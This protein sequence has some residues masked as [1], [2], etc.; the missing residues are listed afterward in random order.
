MDNKE[1]YLDII[2]REKDYKEIRS[3]TFRTEIGIRAIGQ[4]YHDHSS[5][6]NSQ[7]NVLR[8]KKNIEYRLFSASHQYLLLLR[9]LGS[10]ENHLKNLF[11][12]NPQ[13]M[14]WR[15]AEMTNPYFD[16]VETQLSSIFDSI[17]FHISSVFDYLSH[18]ICYIYFTNKQK[19][20][21]WTKLAKKV[22][23]DFKGKFKFC[24]TVDEIDR[25]FV[26]QLYNY[27]SR[28][29]HNK[30]DHHT[31]A[32]IFESDSKKFNL[33]INCSEES[34]KKF[35]SVIKK[36]TNEKQKITLAFLGSWLIKQTFYEIENLLDSI[37][38]DLEDNSHFHINLR[39]PKGGP[40]AL[41]IF[42]LNQETNFAE[43]AS[44]SIWKDY[45]KKGS[46]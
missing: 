39:K 32:T 13:F 20:L 22:R 14:D 3:E 40:N 24:K 45:K 2:D 41:M 31:F 15:T 36:K 12:E 10:A 38:K 8:L 26:G 28:L 30:R 23:G 46:S 43:P 37:K 42:S 9:E 25:R 44:Q 19:T 29:L 16:Q 34:L 7:E 18:S 6:Q 5:D 21:Y 27:R 35:K 11:E 33:K 17:I 1:E 4:I